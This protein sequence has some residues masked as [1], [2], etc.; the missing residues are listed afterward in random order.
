M[1]W[2]DLIREHII[3]LGGGEEQ[4]PPQPGAALRDVSPTPPPRPAASTTLSDT[5]GDDRYV[6]ALLKDVDAGTPEIYRN[7]QA[8]LADL[9]AI[10]DMGARIAAA[11]KMAAKAHGYKPADIRRAAK[12]RLGLLDTEQSEFDAQLQEDT[13]QNV[14]AKEARIKEI[15]GQLADIERQMAELQTRKADLTG[16]QQTLR[17]QVAEAAQK[18]ERMRANFTAAFATVKQRLQ[19]EYDQLIAYLK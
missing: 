12:E 19:S 4:A 17:T 5:S 2:R 16:Q 6:L 14:R 10:P 15:D 8:I 11:I 9:S 1:S 3:D 13:D 18:T 7:F